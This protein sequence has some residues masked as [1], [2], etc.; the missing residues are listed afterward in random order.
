MRKKNHKV[1]GKVANVKI[2]ANLGFQMPNF[3]KH[4]E[5]KKEERDP[6]GAVGAIGCKGG[7]LTRQKRELGGVWET[8]EVKKGGNR[9][10]KVELKPFRRKTFKPKIVISPRK[11][12][13]GRA[14]GGKG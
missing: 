1:W 9:G 2:I 12:G 8:E 6:V 4:N 14:D 13:G 5:T 11:K 3:Q 7:L 10:K